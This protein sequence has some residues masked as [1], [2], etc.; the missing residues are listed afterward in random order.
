MIALPIAMVVHSGSPTARGPNAAGLTQ[1]PALTGG[2]VLTVLGC[3]LVLVPVLV[4]TGFDTSTTTA[5]TG[6]DGRWAART[7]TGP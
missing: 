2:L 5:A 6:A 1:A 4:L 3:T 7:P